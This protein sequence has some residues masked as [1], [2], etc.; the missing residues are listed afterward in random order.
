MTSL[1]ACGHC[2]WWE[3]MVGADPKRGYCH[4]APPTADQETGAGIWPVT[5]QSDHCGAFRIAEALAG[6]ADKRARKPQETA[7]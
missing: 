4:G 7:A 6:G 5:H 3:R 1:R 2:H